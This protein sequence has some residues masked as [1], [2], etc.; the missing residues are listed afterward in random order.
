MTI[1]E[2][3]FFME[4]FSLDKKG[5]TYFKNRTKTHHIYIVDSSVPHAVRTAT[6]LIL[7]PHSAA[8]RDTALM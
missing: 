1:R 5:N 4:C 7:D 2:Y 6:F 8:A 3:S